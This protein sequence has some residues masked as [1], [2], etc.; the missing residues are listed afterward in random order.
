MEKLEWVVSGAE[1]GVRL[2]RYL[3]EKV[4]GK[5]RTMI[6]REIRA[7]RVFADGVPVEHPSQELRGGEHVVWE[8]EPEPILSPRPVAVSIL[9]EDEALLVVD[10]PVGQV[11]HPGAGKHGPT[12]VEG[13]L[14]D[15]SLPLTEDPAR[16]GIVHRLDKETSGLI[17]VA[18]TKSALDSLK[19]QF[20]E[21]RVQKAYLALAQGV[22]DEDEGAIDAPIARDPAHPRRMAV[23]S[24]GRAAETEFRVLERREA[25][26][27]LLV[28]PRTGR[29]HQVRVHLR[30]TGHP[31]LGDGLYGTGLAE[32]LFLHAWRIEFTHPVSGARVRFEAPVPGLS[33]PI[34]TRRSTG[35][36]RRSEVVEGRDVAQGDPRVQQVRADPQADEDE[37][38]APYDHGGRRLP[39]EPRTLNDVGAQVEDQGSCRER[40]LGDE[41]EDQSQ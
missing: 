25:T 9:Y 29:T 41:E 34:P 14:V 27:L 11:V 4:T 31:V 33:R 20:A 24:E 8:S 3:A 40:G 1:K 13:L 17:V 18:K 23:R 32:R 6:Q 16:P 19:A 15:R 37:E 21:R 39:Y 22:I 28:F 5:S 2:D 26:T 7:G 30:Y 38:R 35:R 36:N 10:K 12:L